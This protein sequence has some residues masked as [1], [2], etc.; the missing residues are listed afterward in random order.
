MLKV[1]SNRNLLAAHLL[2]G[3]TL[4]YAFTSSALNYMPKARLCFESIRR[5]HPNIRLVY[6]LGDKLP[7][8]SNV[9]YDFFDE[10]ITVEQLSISDRLSWIFQHT[11]IELCT[12][13]K[14]FVLQELLARSDCE[15]VYYFDPDIVL[16]SALED[17]FDEMKSSDILL[18]PHQTTPEPAL[19][20]VMR[21]EIDSLRYGIYNLGF[22]G[23]KNSDVG[24]ALAQWWSERLRLFCVEDLKDG[25]FTDQK[26]MNHV[27]SMFDGVNI[28]KNPRFNVATWNLIARHVHGTSLEDLKV[29]DEP[30][31]FYHFTGFDSGAHQKEALANAKGNATV[32][33]M[34]DWYKREISGAQQDPVSRLP[35]HYGYYSDGTPIAKRHRQLYR[36]KQQLQHRYP[37]PFDATGAPRDDGRPTSFLR[38]LRRFE[39]RERLRRYLPKIPRLAKTS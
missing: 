7:E 10:M 14:P 32:Q 6:A 36:R 3:I 29:F 16:F 24:H 19:P 35:W 22:I 33:M 28:L 12:A 38:W 18:T 15:A 4:I 27:P 30:L 5:F 17:L 9:K 39:K 2:K 31:G 26:W 1:T 13:I 25:L 11:I 34:I 8:G 21:K 23:V 20:V 37:N